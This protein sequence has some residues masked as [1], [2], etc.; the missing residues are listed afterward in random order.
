MWCVQVPKSP[1]WPSTAPRT[2][3]VS[4]VTGDAVGQVSTL[5]YCSIQ[6]RPFCLIA[7]VFSVE[8][9][10]NVNETYSSMQMPK[11]E[12]KT[13]VIDDYSTYGD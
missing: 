8:T 13:I 9:N 11:V 7:E 5:K 3:R 6:L 2:S 1:A 10:E 12:N 4:S